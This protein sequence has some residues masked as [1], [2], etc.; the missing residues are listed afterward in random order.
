MMNCEDGQIMKVLHE[1]FMDSL[2]VVH[3]IDF[4]YKHEIFSSE[5]CEQFEE[6]K[7]R[8]KR[9]RKFLFRLPKI[10][11]SVNVLYEALMSNGYEFLAD[12]IK[13]CKSNNTIHRQRKS[14]FFCTNRTRL[15]NYRHK[16]KRLTHSG[17]H[18]EF[19][20]KV[21]KIQNSWRQAEET[22]FKNLSEDDRQ[23][24]ADH[25]FF[26]LDAECEYK[27]LIFDKNFVNSEIFQTIRDLTKYTSEANIP[28]MLC[29]ARYGSAI[30]MADESSFEEGLSY[31]QEAKQKF[32]LVHSCRE[33]GIVLYIEYNMEYNNWHTK[34]SHK[35]EPDKKKY[36]LSLGYRAVDH[37]QQEGETNPEV[38]EDF[39]RMFRLKLSHLCLGI[40]LFGDYLNTEVTHQDVNESKY[41]LKTIEDNNDMWNRMETRWKW[42]YYI[43][44]ARISYLDGNLCEALDNTRHAL[45][46][47]IEGN[48]TNEI[49]CTREN[50]KNIENI[51]TS[52]IS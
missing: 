26:A 16:L 21:Q 10:L 9:T 4:F 33:T 35:M 12:R 51:I 30:F 11:T 1:D 7:P 45:H 27:R 37:F 25:Y 17:K 43:D 13:D 42:F 52:Q 29:S 23:D 47:A 20:R 39:T 32:D 22:R 38:S 46:L 3:V 18:A 36:L 6:I 50:I 44:K 49:R 34:F 8:A 5:E 31:I 2:D 14:G 40:G 24:L 15:V 19:R 48:Y 41:L 28:N